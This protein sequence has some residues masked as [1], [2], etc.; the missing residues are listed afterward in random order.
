MLVDFYQSLSA[1]DRRDFS[2]I[3]LGI[4]LDRLETVKNTRTLRSISVFAG[5][6]DFG[7]DL[8]GFRE[9]PLLFLSPFLRFI[10][11]FRE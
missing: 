8:L 9:I 1:G 11:G 4:E 6:K 5:L 7:W 2:P 3:G 10:E